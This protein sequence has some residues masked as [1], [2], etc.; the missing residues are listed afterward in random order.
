MP[1]IIMPDDEDYVPILRRGLCEECAEEPGFFG[2][3]C[4][5]KECRYGKANN[6]KN[7]E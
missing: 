4:T 2:P 7:K 3:Y 5:N 1:I 6:E